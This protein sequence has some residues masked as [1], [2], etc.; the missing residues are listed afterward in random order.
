MPKL[1][2]LWVCSVL[3]TLLGY[4]ARDE[5]PHFQRIVKKTEKENYTNC[6]VIKKQQPQM[7]CVFS[8]QAVYEAYP[9]RLLR[10]SF[11][12]WSGQFSGSFSGQNRIA[13][14][15]WRDPSPARVQTGAL[16]TG[17]PRQYQN[18]YSCGNT[19]DPCCIARKHH[20]DPAGRRFSIPD[21]S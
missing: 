10:G 8:L 13:R 3:A 7:L 12:L 19:A 2:I 6:S 15:N 21:H 9:L 18:E 16:G 5:R 20:A 14:S 17:G 1:D 4:V 11:R